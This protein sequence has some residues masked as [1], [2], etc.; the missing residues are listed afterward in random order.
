MTPL[1]LATL[2]IVAWASVRWR[3]VED[4]ELDLPLTLEM[5][6][7]LS[8]A[9]LGFDAAIARLIDSQPVGRPL[10]EELGIYQNELLAGVSRVQCLRR[11]RQRVDVGP[12]TIF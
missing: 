2:L 8:E 5:L 12:V 1:F 11:L 9:G 3:R 7:T 10:A 6:A 4:V